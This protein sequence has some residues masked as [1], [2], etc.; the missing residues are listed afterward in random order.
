MSEQAPDENPPAKQ[1]G[2]HSENPEPEEENPMLVYEK[3]TNVSIDENICTQRSA[4]LALPTAC[5]LSDM[6]LSALVE[7]CMQEIENYRR[8]EPSNDPHGHSA[9]APASPEKCPMGATITS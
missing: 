3:S 2:H 7:R 4:S 6:S 8:R 9:T 1:V 5:L